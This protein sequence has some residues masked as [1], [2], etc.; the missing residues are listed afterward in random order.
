MTLGTCQQCGSWIDGDPDTGYVDE[1][2]SLE[3][4]DEREARHLR[5]YEDDY[6]RR[7]AQAQEEYQ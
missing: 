1:L 3:C 5:E 6:E 7:E 4:E 2:C